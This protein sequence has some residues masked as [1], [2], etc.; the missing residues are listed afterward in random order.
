MRIVL[1]LGLLFLGVSACN[2]EAQEVELDSQERKLS[3][4]IGQQ[5]GRELKAQGI[6]LD[7]KALA[8]SIEDVMSGRESRLS[9]QQM[10][11]V[12]MKATQDAMEG[13]ERQSTANKEDG[14]RF[15]E[16]NK[17]KDGVQ[18]TE[19]GLQYRVIEE[20]EGRSP[21]STDEVVVHYRGRLLDGTEFDSS[22]ARNQPARFPVTGVI[23]GWVEAL[24]LMKPGAKWELFIPSELAYGERGSPPRIPPNAVLI[25]EVELV[26]IVGS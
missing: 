5:I 16:E 14:G 8:M 21:R 18:T 1:V 24:Q 10:Q 12:M 23:P 26:E 2:R 17:A 13:A 7:S 4:L 19:S 9:E 25:F 11:E 22:Y 20:G 6:E 3:Y 15:L